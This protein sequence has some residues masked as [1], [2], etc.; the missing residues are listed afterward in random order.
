VIGEPVEV[1]KQ[2]TTI[3]LLCSDSNLRLVMQEV[4]E[5]KGYVVLPASDLSRAVDWMSRCKPDLL[6]VRPYLSGISGYEAA[7]YLRTKCHGI[8]IMMVSGFLQDDRLQYQW[9]LQGI[10]VFPK[11]FTGE[12][13]LQKIANVLAAPRPVPTEATSSSGAIPPH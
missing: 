8:R 12:E 11:P 4:L 1:V 2:Q 3:L 9:S 13:F 10:E 5:E 6:L 7:L